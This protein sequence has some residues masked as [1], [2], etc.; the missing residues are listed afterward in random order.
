MKKP[1]FVF[2]AWALVAY[3]KNEIPAADR[4]A[5][6]LHQAGNHELDVFLSLINLGEVYYTLGRTKG[7][8]FAEQILVH[9]R[10]LPINLLALEETTVF[11]AATYKTI[12]A[13]SYADS[14]ALAAAVQHDATLITGDPEFDKLH[15]QFAIER[16]YRAH[17][18]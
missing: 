7:R 6:L 14:F 17:R 8:A 12:Y 5:E 4:V 16:L 3:F 10:Q 9:I 18:N 13:I 1:G 15:G 11:Q 2:D